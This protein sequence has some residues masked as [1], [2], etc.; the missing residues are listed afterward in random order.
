MGLC[1]ASS[2]PKLDSLSCE[3]E[4]AVLGSR[5][6]QCYFVTLNMKTQGLRSSETPLRVRG[7]CFSLQLCDTQDEV[8]QTLAGG[9]TNG[10]GELSRRLR[11][12]VLWRVQ[13]RIW[14]SLCGQSSPPLSSRAYPQEWL[15]GVVISSLRVYTN[16]PSVL[17]RSLLTSLLIGQEEAGSVSWC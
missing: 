11:F 4:G 17:Q 6:G 2:Y 14:L 15:D 12:L 3:L 9:V 7:L 16:D 1:C 8:S 5:M 10:L 13:S